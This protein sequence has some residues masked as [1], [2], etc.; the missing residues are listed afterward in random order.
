MMMP[1]QLLTTKLY[2]SSPRPDQVPRS[3]LLRTLDEGLLAKVRDLEIPL[4]SVNRV[5]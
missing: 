2:V 5:G 4:I 1:A 3:D